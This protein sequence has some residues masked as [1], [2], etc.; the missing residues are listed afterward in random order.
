MNESHNPRSERRAGILLLEIVIAAG[1]LAAALVLIAQST[2]L[3]AAQRRAQWQRFLATQEAANALEQI[4]GRGPETLNE[5]D[6]REIQLS[7]SALRQLPQADLKIA[8]ETP[9]TPDAAETDVE[10]GASDGTMI[11]VVVRWISVS[12]VPQTVEL[13]DW[14]WPVN[15]DPAPS[16]APSQD[17]SE[18]TP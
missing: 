9:P 3:G 18:D 1:V 12:Q 5:V 7:E 4:R 16:P 13:V 8:L 15:D 6:L 10:E 11:R 2:I 14:Y 17:R